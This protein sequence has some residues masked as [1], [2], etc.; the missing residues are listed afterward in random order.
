VLIHHNNKGGETFSGAQELENFSDW[1]ITIKKELDPDANG[2]SIFHKT[3]IT[4]YKE[5]L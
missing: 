3:I 5:R 4:I 2:I 1:R